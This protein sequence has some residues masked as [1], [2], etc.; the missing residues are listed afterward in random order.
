M[1][2]AVIVIHGIARQMRYSIEDRFATALWNE[3]NGRAPTDAGGE[4]ASR[5]EKWQLTSEFVPHQSAADPELVRLTVDRV[6]QPGGHAFDVQEAYWSP[7]DKGRTTPL[8][9][10]AW[11]LQVVFVPLNRNARFPGWFWKA[12]FDIGYLVAVLLLAAVFVGLALW[13]AGTSYR[14]V[15]A[16]VCATPSP[17]AT[18]AP[19]VTAPP[20]PDVLTNPLKL[21]TLF[22]LRETML[23]L[24]AVAGAV[25]IAQAF[26]T[27]AGALMRGKRRARARSAR[28]RKITLRI[29]VVLG[30]GT[31]LLLLAAYVP[32]DEG[33]RFGRSIWL[34]VGTILALQGASSLGR[35]FLVDRLGDV[36]IYTTSDENSAYFVCRE[37]IRTLTERVLLDTIARRDGERPY[38]DAVVVAGHSL[39]GT[40]GLDALLRVHELHEATRYDAHP[41]VSDED[42]GRVRAFVTFGTAL[43]KTKYF[44]AARDVSFSAKR[45]RWSAQ[46]YGH[47]FTPDPKVLTGTNDKGA[48]DP[49]M[50]GIFWMNLWYWTDIIANE[51]ASYRSHEL[52]RRW[53]RDDG[54]CRVVCLNQRLAVPPS[55]FP[56]DH[57]IEDAGFWTAPDPGAP[58]RSPHPLGV[59]DVLTA[60]I[61]YRPATPPAVR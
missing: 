61:G 2:V 11:L 56:H 48:E 13:G 25:C 55:I 52:P 1:R 28:Y 4:D 37:A 42:W 60:L 58:K 7:I 47:L 40:I 30:I 32:F 34:F 23:V 5:T 46:L 59:L 18:C 54:P 10:A 29:A 19:T 9:V 57:Y 16:V 38:Y 49:A 20:L 3:L 45:E 17:P 33:N 22:D 36:Q 43:E 6:S 35:A 31:I 8:S 44:T 41:I 50:R 24:A 26:S 21:I 12:A 39:G 27:T 14:Q 53:D 51:I 15:V